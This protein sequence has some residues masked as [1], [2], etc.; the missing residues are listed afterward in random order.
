MFTSRAEYRLLLREDNADLRLTETGHELGL[1]DEPRWQF[2]TTKREMIERET[3]RLA[4]TLVRPGDL[5][6]VHEAALGRP[7]R[8]ESKALELLKRPEL[9]YRALTG[10][11]T[12]GARAANQ[13]ESPEMSEQIENQV[14]IE[15]RYSGYLLRQQHEIDRARNNEQTSLPEDLDYG[16]V[17]GLSNEIRQK[18]ADNRPATL[19]QATR[20]SGMT[21]A[22]IALLL[23]HLKKRQLKSA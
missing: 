7:L 17:R 12:V 11:K 23:V 5:D 16:S 19:G 20:I 1:V 9:D 15:A 6:E 13:S 22:A 18:L 3:A 14:E 8:R 10:I 21:P 4:A 2:F